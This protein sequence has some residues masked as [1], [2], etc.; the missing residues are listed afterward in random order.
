MI[1]N[2]KFQ[3]LTSSRGVQL[4]YFLNL[5]DNYDMGNDYR[6]ILV[7]PPGSQEKSLVEAYVI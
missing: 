3:T 5:P 1:M 4:E 7:I 6:V 2:R